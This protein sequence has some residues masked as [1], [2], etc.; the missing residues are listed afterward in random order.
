MSSS[1]VSLHRQCDFSHNS[2]LALTHIQKLTAST[3]TSSPTQAARVCRT[4]PGL[5]Y[6]VSRS[7]SFAV[8]ANVRTVLIRLLSSHAPHSFSSRQLSLAH[9]RSRPSYSLRPQRLVATQATSFHELTRH[10]S[11]SRKEKNSYQEEKR[12]ETDPSKFSNTPSAKS[13]HAQALW[14]SESGLM[15]GCS[16]SEAV[17]A[18][19]CLFNKQ[20]ILNS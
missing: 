19:R 8:D 9:L 10:L 7:L 20:A 3:S 5:S 4:R 13:D 16:L 14:K 15:G 12:K 1:L 17:G 6:L 11:D 18:A 2:G